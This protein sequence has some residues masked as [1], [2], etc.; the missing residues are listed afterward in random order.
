MQVQVIAN[1]QELIY[2][3]PVAEEVEEEEASEIFL[4]ESETNAAD[5]GADGTVEKTN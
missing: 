2:E 5:V 4:Q 1:E 3:E